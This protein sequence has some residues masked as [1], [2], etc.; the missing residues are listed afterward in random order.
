[1]SYV[2]VFIGLGERG[3]RGSLYLTTAI[4]SIGWLRKRHISLPRPEGSP[5]QKLT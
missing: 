3:M 4:W 2:M 1:M 5:D